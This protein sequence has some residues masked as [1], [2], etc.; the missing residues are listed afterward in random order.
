MVSRDR[1]RF[2][3]KI[4]DGS[5]GKTY[6]GTF[7]TAEEAALAFARERSAC[8][9]L[10][11]TLLRAAPRRHR[12]ALASKAKASRTR[13][14]PT[15]DDD[16]DSD[17]EDSYSEEPDEDEEGSDYGE[18]H[19]GT[20]NDDDFDMLLRRVRA[21]PQ[22]GNGRE[23]RLER[24]LR[25][26]TAASASH[27]VKLPT[28]DA[29]EEDALTCGIGLEDIAGGGRPGRG[30]GGGAG[31]RAGAGPAGRRGRPE[32]RGQGRRRA[33]R[34]AAPRDPAE[35]IRP[36]QPAECARLV[37]AHASVPAAHEAARLR[38]RD[39][40]VAADP[41]GVQVLPRPDR[42]QHEQVRHDDGGAHSAVLYWDET[43]KAL[44]VRA[45]GAPAV[46]VTAT[47]IPT[48]LIQFAL[49]HLDGANPLNGLILEHAA[50]NG[51]QLAAWK[52][53]PF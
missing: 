37:P 21:V 12:Q 52:D 13:R 3:A 14:R 11:T 25:Q 46:T 8:K 50:A 18:S 20:R 40:H 29:P 7:D 33:G 6:L 47:S 15:V 19:N 35:A 43:S 31:V 4:S 17:S 39:Q 45:D 53:M 48:N 1:S 27:A 42:V 22:C 41:D 44:S 38:A 10:A 36:D 5:G 16:S 49:G 30:G 2:Q 28:A 26:R 51:N 24:R 9:R 23:Q 34:A 32:G